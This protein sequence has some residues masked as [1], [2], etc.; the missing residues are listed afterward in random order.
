MDHLHI[1]AE[2]WHASPMRSLTS[3]VILA[4][5]I[6]LWL[7]PTAIVGAEATPL[8][9]LSTR[10]APLISG[11]GQRVDASVTLRDRA[12]LRVRVTDFDGRTVRELSSGV[13]D[14]GTISVSWF[15]RDDDGARAADG[16]YRIVAAATSV[17]DGSTDR[18]EAW[19]TVADRAIYP[20]RPGFISVAVDPGHGGKL[21]GAVGADGTREADINLDIGLRLARMLEGAGVRVAITRTTDAFV[22]DPPQERTGDGIVDDDDELAARPDVAN[23]ARADLFISIHNNI[24][25]NE[26]VGGPST[27]YFDERPFGARSER[28]ARLVQDEMVAALADISAGYQPYD[29]GTL[30]YPYYV[31]RDYD[32]PRLRR[33]TQMPGVLSEGMFLSNARELRFLKRPSVRARMAVAYYDAIAA[34]LARRSTHVGY[35]LLEGPVGPVAAGESVSYQVEVRNQGNETMREW[36]LGVAALPATSHYIGRIRDGTP[37]GQARLPRLEPGQ[38]ATISLDVVAPDAGGDWVLL[39]DARTRDGDRAAEMGSP[40]L[41]VPLSTLSPPVPAPTE[42]VP[43]E[44]A[45][46]TESAAPTASPAPSDL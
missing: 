5:V 8:V 3:G 33:P 16:P 21:P 44:P 42:P 46:S 19:V 43:T 10:G 36:R 34:Y 27:Y 11:A 45:A 26:S 9:T 29:H 30:I 13:R 40:M 15:G 32:P 1:P 12:E 17:A 24:A 7:V 41:Q 4:L 25:V 38:A 6:L 2:G 39:F 14:P 37:V 35:Q 23:I 18:S 28:L 20:A 31:L 22:N